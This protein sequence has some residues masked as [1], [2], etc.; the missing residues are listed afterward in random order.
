[1]M[2]KKTPGVRDRRAW[3]AGRVLALGAG[4][5]WASVASAE[6][7]SRQP[8]RSEQP[9]LVCLEDCASARTKCSD[10]CKTHAENGLNVCLKACG[11]MEQE[12]RS[13]CRAPRS[14]N[15]DK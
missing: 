10:V 4:L 3:R 12:C 11:Q 5:W 2:R 15:H 6:F 1:M 8:E 7:S 9:E 14:M 13:D